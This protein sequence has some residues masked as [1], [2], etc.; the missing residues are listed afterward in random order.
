MANEKPND[1]IDELSSDTTWGKP[2]VHFDRKAMIAYKDH[3]N[4]FALIG[5]CLIVAMI[6]TLVVGSI[7]GLLMGHFET[8]IFTDGTANTCQLNSKTGDI[9]NVE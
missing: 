2:S 1:P 4:T 6:V 9:T 7:F 8:A 5:E 3:L